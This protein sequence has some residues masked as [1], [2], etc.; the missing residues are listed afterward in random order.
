MEFVE[1]G[2]VNDLDEGQMVGFEVDD[3]RILLAKV[4]G[5]FFAIGATC[6]HERSNLDQ[7]ALLGH[8]VYCPLHYS[9]FDVRSGAVLGPPAECPVPKH[10]V[11]VEDGKV[12]V[13]TQPCAVESAAAAATPPPPAATTS[14]E[15][16]AVPDDASSI[17]PDDAS[18][19]SQDLGADPAGVDQYVVAADAASIAQEVAADV[20]ADVATDGAGVA[21]A[22]PEPVGASRE[23]V[24]Q[25]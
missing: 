13:C 23:L 11:R 18:S 4:E 24:E 3:R 9:A 22:A 2:S 1:V 14:V 19:I 7:G 6:T 20:A 15:P 12:L 5:E 25:I 10:E 21:Q 8:V 16:D 17:V